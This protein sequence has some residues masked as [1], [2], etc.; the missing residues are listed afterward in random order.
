MPAP[1]AQRGSYA[2]IIFWASWGTDS[3]TPDWIISIVLPAFFSSMV[4]P[5]HTIGVSP[6]AMAAAAFCRTVSFVSPF[7][8]RCSLWPTMV[9]V[10]PVAATI[11]AET[12]PVY[13]PWSCALTSWAP[14]ATRVDVATNIVY[15]TH[16]TTV[17]S[18]SIFFSAVIISFNSSRVPFIFQLP[19]IIFMEFSPFFR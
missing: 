1:I 7:Y 6:A 14:M 5:T 8:W 17:F 18:V 13:A 15:G 12:W 11:L 10:A 4:S 2:M 9:Y 19:A 3:R 16:R